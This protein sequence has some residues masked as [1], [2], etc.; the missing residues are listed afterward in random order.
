MEHIVVEFIMQIKCDKQEA[1]EPKGKTENID[2]RK[3][4]VLKQIPERYFEVVDDHDVNC[5]SFFK[6]CAGLPV[7]AFSD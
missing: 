1:E 4:A 5:Y 2:Q 6:I 3:R 7:A